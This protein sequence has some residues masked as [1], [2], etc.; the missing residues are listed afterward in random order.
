MVSDDPACPP[1][2]RVR[3]G[4]LS[5]DAIPD[6]ETVTARDMLPVKPFKLERVRVTEPDD[7]EGTLIEDGLAARPKSGGK[8]TVTRIVAECDREPELAAT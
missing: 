7:P 8:V 3:L 4:V 2:D 5:D 1:D 6:G